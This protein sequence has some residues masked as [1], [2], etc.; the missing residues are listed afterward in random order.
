MRFTQP[1]GL[2]SGLG[3]IADKHLIPCLHT[4]GCFLSR[5]RY[6]GIGNKFDLFIIMEWGRKGE[7]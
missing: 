3:R 1:D 2:F 5:D 4:G 6:G 7:G